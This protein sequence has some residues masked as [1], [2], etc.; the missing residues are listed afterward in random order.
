MR[1]SKKKVS[2]FNSFDNKND[3]RNVNNINNNKIFLFID[4]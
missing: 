1:V 3:N 4:V 2:I